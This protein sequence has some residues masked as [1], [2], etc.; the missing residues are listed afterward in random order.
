MDVVDLRAV[1]TLLVVLAFAGVCWWAFGAKR[2]ARFEDAAKLP[3]ADEP[4]GGERP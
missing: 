2:K 3:F 4:P 1:A